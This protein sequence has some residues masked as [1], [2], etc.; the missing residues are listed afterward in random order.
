MSKKGIP[1]A[2]LFELLMGNDTDFVNEI[3]H[4][5]SQTGFVA[6]CDY[7]V[8][9]PFSKDIDFLK[10]KVYAA[11][12]R[13]TELSLE[14]K[15]KYHRPETG[16]QRGFT[17][18]GVEQSG[19]SDFL[20]YR[21]HFMVGPRIPEG[22]PILQYQPFSYLPNEPVS[23]V[24]E[25]VFLAEELLEVLENRDMHLFEGFAKALGLPRSY[26][27]S[28]IVWGDS[29]LRLHHYP[30]IEGEVLSANVVNGVKTLN[31]KIKGGKVLN[32]V[33]RAGR[34]TDVDFSAAL[35]GAEVAGLCIEARDGKAVEYTTEPGH[36]VY[37]AGDFAAY[38]TGNLYPSSSHWVSLTQETASKPRLSIVRFTHFRPRCEVKIIDNLRT[39]ENLKKFPDTYEGVLLTQRLY[40]IGYLTE[41]KKNEMIDTVVNK[42]KPDSQIVDEIIDWEIQN[43]VWK[44][45][46]YSE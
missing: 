20:E 5:W 22:H 41:Q 40:E 33:V 16:G 25:L 18:N 45:S 37:N 8:G 30:A 46:R 14:I 32:N 34:H 27:S 17:P 23:E 19:G 31:L 12:Q 42:L 24:P 44:L 3:H 39:E 21:E 26:F 4:A 11:F 6:I 13:F 38:E 28:R 15:M 10:S 7:N 35:L 36:I 9:L 2:S 29:S 1:S 43:D